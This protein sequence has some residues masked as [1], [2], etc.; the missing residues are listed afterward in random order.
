MSN[1]E[2]QLPSQLLYT[3]ASVLQKQI[4]AE[5]KVPDPKN[6]DSKRNDREGSNRNSK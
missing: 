1:H 4:E 5:L 2:Q 3:E 6:E